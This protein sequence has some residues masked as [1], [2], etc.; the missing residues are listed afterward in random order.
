[1]PITQLHLGI[2]S[3]FRTKLLAVRYI[4][5]CNKSAVNVCQ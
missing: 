3:S 5:V 4:S 1:M 2:A